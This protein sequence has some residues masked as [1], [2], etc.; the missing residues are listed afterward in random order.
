MPTCLI[1]QEYGKCHNR[2]EGN[3]CMNKFYVTLASLL[4]RRES[5]DRLQVPSCPPINFT[6]LLIMDLI[7]IS[8]RT[9]Y[10]FH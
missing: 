4:Q 3:Q 1:V 8:K 2:A 6:G 9:S 7:Q 5:G 10:H